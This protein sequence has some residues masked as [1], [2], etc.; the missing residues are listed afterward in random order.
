MLLLDALLATTLPGTGTHILQGIDLLV[1]YPL[2]GSHW[3][4][5]EGWRRRRKF[6]ATRTFFRF[7]PL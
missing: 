2:I 4:S 5:W 6:G 3:R 7:G 1:Y